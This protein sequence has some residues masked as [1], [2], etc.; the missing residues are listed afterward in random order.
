MVNPGSNWPNIQQGALMPTRLIIDM[1][2]GR[3]NPAIDLED[4]ELPGRMRL[5]NARRLLVEAVIDRA[6]P[7]N[8]GY[9]GI[10]LEET[11]PRSKVLR[12]RYIAE[13][14]KKI[15]ALVESTGHRDLADFILGRI[16]EPKNVER[17]FK[18]FHE[19]LSERERRPPGKPKRP[20]AC[21]CAPLYEPAWW[22]DGGQRQFNNNCYNYS[23]NYR[24]DTFAQPG[25]AAGQMYTALTCAAVHTAALADDVLDTKLANRCPPEGHLMALVVAPGFDFHWYRKGRDGHWTHK[26]GGTAAT[27]V[28]NSGRIITD[29]RTADR[30]PYT[31]FC[32]F[33]VVMH[34]HIKIR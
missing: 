19:Y 4:L 20:V 18:T 1:F 30:G 2:S 3:P 11:N 8:L 17:A 23:T 14:S 9:R 24:T 32:H 6:Q 22:N 16:T 31:D 27:N 34:G 10:I 7:S 29:P 15:A 5:A 12:R 21:K 33:M 28:D 25:Q 13:D 26:P